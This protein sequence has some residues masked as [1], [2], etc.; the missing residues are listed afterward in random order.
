MLSKVKMIELSLDTLKQI[1]YDINEADTSD[2]YDLNAKYD[3]NIHELEDIISNHVDDSYVGNGIYHIFP[4]LTMGIL[5]FHTYVCVLYYKPYE[6]F[7]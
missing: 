6:L 7:Q 1:S 4:L 5:L 2:D 3:I